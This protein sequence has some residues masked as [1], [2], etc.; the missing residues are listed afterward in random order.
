[1]NLQQ[2]AERLGADRFLGV[3]VRDFERGGRLQFAFLVAAG[4]NPDTRL[5]D[6]GSGV[7]RLGYWLIHFLN[8]GCYCG[9]EPHAERLQ[10]GMHAVLESETLHAKRPRFDT[11]DR[12]DTSVFGEKFDIF[13]AFS[14]WTHAA[15]PQIE[16]MLDSFVRD[17]SEGAV[18]LTSY[19][20]AGWT[21]HDYNG[22]RWFGT[23]HE[24]DVAGCIAHSTRWIETV[25]RARDLSVRRRHLDPVYR[26]RWLEIR[27]SI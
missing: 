11:N 5:V 22:D 23:S 27:R 17:A 18:F 6:I 4:M 1:V 13:L 20:P 7:L 10:L 9:I 8:P 14:I 24:S 19:S 16:L 26:Q 12:F 25:C 15:K 3:P 2:T 21:A